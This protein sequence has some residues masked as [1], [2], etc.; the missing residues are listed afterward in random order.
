METKPCIECGAVKPHDEF[1]RHPSWCDDG[2]M[3]VCKTCH[4]ARMK[5]QRLTDPKVQE[6]DRIR[7]QHPERKAYQR[8]IADRWDAEHPLAY[9]ARYTVHNAV[10]DGRLTRQPC[11]ICGTTEKIHAHHRD[12]SKPLDVVWL[13]VKCHQRIHAAFPELHGHHEQASLSAE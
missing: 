4:K 8:K 5:R 7:Y 2:T 3:G 13:C 12:Y 10:R 6:Y 11:A 9:K 1:Y